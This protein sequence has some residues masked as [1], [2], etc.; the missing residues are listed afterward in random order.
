MPQFL[1][2][3][4][5]PRLIGEAL[6][7]LQTRYFFEAVSGSNHQRLGLRVPS[8]SQQGRAKE[9]LRLRDAPVIRFEDPLAHAQDLTKRGFG[10]RTA[11]ERDL[12]AREIQHHDGNSRVLIAQ[13]RTGDSQG[14]VEQ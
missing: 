5:K 4:R 2:Q 13:Q 6:T 12:N 8:L 9:A 10:L 11:P 14:F 7:A 3:R 1:A